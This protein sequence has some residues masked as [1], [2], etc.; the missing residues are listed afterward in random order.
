MASSPLPDPVPSEPLGGKRRQTLLATALFL[1]CLA[2]IL[3]GVWTEGPTNAVPAV[4]RPDVTAR[5]KTLAE[6]DVRF[7]AWGTS[8]NAWALLHTPFELFDAEQ[9]YP[10]NNTLALGHPMISLGVL[11]A[12]VRLLVGDPVLTYNVVVALVMM[13]SALAMFLLIRAW[14]GSAA[15]GIAAGIIFV[16]HPVVLGRVIHLFTYD[17]SWTLWALLFGYR[18]VSRGRMRDALLLAAA[19]TMQMGAS[20]YPAISCLVIGLPFAAWA[21]WRRHRPGL[22]LGPISVALML[23]ALGGYLVYAPFVELH[24]Q[25]GSDRTAQFFA[26]WRDFLPGGVRYEGWWI[27]LLA[28]AAWLPAV[29]RSGS[30]RAG[31][32]MAGAT[33]NPRWAFLAAAVLVTLLATG[34]GVPSPTNPDP[35]FTIPGVYALLAAIL[36]GFETVRVPKFFAGGTHLALAL[37]AGLGSATVISLVTPRHRHLAGV[38]L[39]TLTCFFV[40]RQP[41]AGLGP[42][43][44][45]Y[46]LAIR[47]SA[48]KLEFFET[49]AANGNRGPLL[50]IFHG[51]NDLTPHAEAALLTSYHHRRS[52]ACYNSFKPLELGAVAELSRE[53]PSPAAVKEAARLGFTTLL[54][55]HPDHSAK[56]RA[57][58]NRMK[59]AS[60]TPN[61][62]LRLIHSSESLSAFT[63][64]A[65]D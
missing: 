56:A 45:V 16:F 35:L 34:G 41:L 3:L 43:A 28:A 48:E 44:S 63:L 23:T 60:D 59:T 24:G 8:R 5:W 19:L 13:S 42:V 29:P 25:M 54:L 47:P 62:G 51:P 21:L 20:Y 18:L 52:S 26:A 46:P 15:A 65:N 22:A 39:V 27:L 61:S 50:E 11:G 4:T 49:L 33:E 14:T 64:S 31:T 12:P 1:L 53:M 6:N 2:Y 37:L 30:A 7:G 58:L 17:Q 40:L 36:P 55:H 9:C 10:A 38:I 32:T 57:T